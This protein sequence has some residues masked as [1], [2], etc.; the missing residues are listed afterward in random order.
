MASF[1]NELLVKVTAP[2]VSSIWITLMLA[3]L[4]WKLKS[5]IVKIP[6]KLVESI[7]NEADLYEELYNT[8]HNYIE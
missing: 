3:L 5:F 7:I 1:V 8:F 2:T 4:F 6:F